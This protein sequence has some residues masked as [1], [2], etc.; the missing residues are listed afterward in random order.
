MPPLRRLPP[1]TQRKREDAM[2]NDH[3]HD[4]G[5][6]DRHGELG[7]SDPMLYIIFGYLC[8]SV[9]ACAVLLIP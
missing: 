4:H 7:L 2:P 5:H 6:D 1:R 8:M 3:D 9:C